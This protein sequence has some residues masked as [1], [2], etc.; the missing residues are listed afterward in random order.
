MSIYSLERSIPQINPTVVKYFLH[1][2]PYYAINECKK[3]NLGWVRT[4]IHIEQNTITT[5]LSFLRFSM[6]HLKIHII[7]WFWCCRRP[8]CQSDDIECGDIIGMYKAGWYTERQ[9]TS[10]HVWALMYT[11]TPSNGFFLTSCTTRFIARFRASRR[12]C[13][14]QTVTLILMKSLQ[15]NSLLKQWD[16]HQ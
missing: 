16:L 13:R 9:T 6:L 15:H 10:W 3:L 4:T 14:E 1:T 5:G 11:D 12:W 8:Y 2:C 7:T